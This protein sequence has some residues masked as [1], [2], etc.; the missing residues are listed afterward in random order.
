MHSI[1]PHVRVR[2]RA[3]ANRRRLVLC[4][5]V[6]LLLPLAGCGRAKARR[7]LKK[8][9]Y[10]AEILRRESMGTIGRDA[11]F[12]D[13]LLAN[14]DPEIRRWCALALGRIADP[15]GLDLLYGA[16]GHEDAGTRAAAAFAVG[17]MQ[18]RERLAARCA[19]AHPETVPR[20][21]RLLDDPS[22]AVRIRAVEAIG[23]AAPTEVAA[24]ILRRIEDPPVQASPLQRMYLDAAITALARLG[25]TRALGPLGRLEHSADARNRRSAAEARRRIL[26]AS[27][28]SGPL[29]QPCDPAS[30]AVPIPERGFVTQAV[31]LALAAYRKN[32]TI[33][34]LETAR[35]P[36]EI[37]LFREDA[38]VTADRFVSMAKRGVY[39]GAAFAPAGASP[40]VESGIPPNR[41]GLRR[42]LRGEVNLQPLERGSVGMPAA[43]W[44]SDAGR[45]FI[46]L[47]PLPYRDGENTCFGRVIR[48]M[49][50][51]ERLAPGD[52]I[53][54]VTIREKISYHDYQRY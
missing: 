2:R 1:V 21:T 53:R 14:P 5:L 46:A 17:T 47:E 15:R 3:A 27:R 36:I 13:N 38:P 42:L 12:R 20:L 52:T 6:L 23:K 24:E 37:E 25:D 39:D 45:F 48:G 30:A 4:L 8:T 28:P 34:R 32:R 18:K 10:Y 54:R 22:F 31:S 33:V 11:F 51:A 40:V 44:G 9:H 26:A 7:A 35:G 16:L 49:E 41:Q 19:A 50:T 43:D 29:P